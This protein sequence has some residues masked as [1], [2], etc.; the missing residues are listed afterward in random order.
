MKTI[1]KVLERPILV[2]AN[3]ISQ[4]VVGLDALELVLDILFGLALERVKDG[5]TDE[6]IGERGHN[7]RER[8]HIL[9][10]HLLNR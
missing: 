9:L 3:V 4:L 10:F 2:V 6:Q 5:R 1:N 7:E 8:A